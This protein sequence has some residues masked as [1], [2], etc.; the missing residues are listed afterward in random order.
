MPGDQFSRVIAPGAP[1]RFDANDN[2]LSTALQY[3]LASY[4]Q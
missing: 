1:Q 2:P 3:P 4:G